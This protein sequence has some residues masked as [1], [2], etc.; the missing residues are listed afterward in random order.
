MKTDIKRTI[1]NFLKMFD[2]RSRIMI[3]AIGL[4]NW[5]SS[6]PTQFSQLYITALGADALQLGSL[7]SIGG[8]TY[9]I[10]SA[11]MGLFVDKFGVKT[12]IVVGL[13][14]S[15]IVS[16]IYSS[17]SNW[18][19]LIPAMI[20]SQISFRMLYSLPDLILIEET[21]P[22]SRAQAMS[23]AR[24]VWSIPS[25]IAPI[26]AAA[27]VVAY[28]GITTEGIRPL[29][30]IQTIFTLFIILFIF[31]TM[32]NRHKKIDVNK[33]FTSKHIG[34]IEGFKELFKGEKW[35]KE[36]TIAMSLFY[37]ASSVS[38]SYVPLWMVNVIKADAY[39]LGIVSTTGI[40]MSTLL[41]I[42][43]G[44]LADRIGRKKAFYLLRP[45]TYAGTFL[46]L[47][48]P[49]PESLILVG[50]IGAVGMMQGLNSICWIPFTTMYWELVP[51]E[52]RGRWFGF[53]GIF[54]TLVTIPAF[55]LGGY[56]WQIGQMELVI[57]L[58][59]IIELLGVI[60]VL[61]KIPD[62]LKR[63]A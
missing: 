15:T 41:Q 52:K 8:I 51:T 43:V 23:F 49:T 48:A 28:G 13:I 18:L 19:M 55:M 36:W 27:I 22:E 39:I 50:V 5:A 37:F 60:P 34:L 31:F 57:L 6:L 45:I 12:A 32:E 38:V 47:F 61:A 11:P 26:M 17:A 7:N 30:I 56:L 1:S 3:T 40:I 44:R 53:T 33:E 24:T 63:S 62:T 59:M 2:K 16:G 4:Y 14:L 20:L 35:L 10:F 58:P 54:N 21:K 46:L 25:I 42:P 29:Y 9:C